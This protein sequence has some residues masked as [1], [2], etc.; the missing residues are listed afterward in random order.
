VSGAAQLAA[1]AAILAVSFAIGYAVARRLDNYGIVDILWSYAF[2]VVAI[3]LAAGGS[4]WWVR[5]ALL[6]GAVAV[7]SVRLGTHLLVRI[8]RHHPTE[9][10]RYRRLRAE[11][12]DGF[13][14]RMG[15]FFQ[16]QAVS[17]VFLALPFFWICRNPAPALR[18]LEW[19]GLAIWALA[20]GG[21]ALADAQLAAFKHRVR[22]GRAKSTGPAEGADSGPG[23]GEGSAVCDAGLWRYSRHPNY[24]FEWLI[25]VG[26]A[27]WAGA[28]PWGWLG[29]LSPASILY[30]LLRVTGI[31]MTEAQSVRS[32]GD[33]YRRYQARTS[34]FVPWFPRS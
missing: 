5:R 17:V 26:Y 34:A 23:T 12:A 3:L 20:I 14:W 19:V 15:G 9:D 25:W 18:P 21:E 7:W 32:K 27:V 8:A 28:S 16:L 31:P 6:A 2:A 24:F 29:L 22:P 10:G 30:L 4:G 11:W 1:A 13:A 33:A